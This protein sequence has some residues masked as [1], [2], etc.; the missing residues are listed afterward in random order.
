MYDWK[1]EFP[2]LVAHYEIEIPFRVIGSQIRFAPGRTERQS[3]L[4]DG[5]NGG[6]RERHGARRTEIGLEMTR[7]RML[8]VAI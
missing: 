6:G 5:Q 4:G 1:V 2:V 8:F 3:T 7:D